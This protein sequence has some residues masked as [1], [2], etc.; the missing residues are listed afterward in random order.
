MELV[1]GFKSKEQKLRLVAVSLVVSVFSLRLCCIENCLE[2]ID[3]VRDLA[4]IEIK[5]TSTINYYYC[6]L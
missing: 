4:L 3:V 2:T 6:C 1:R 5:L